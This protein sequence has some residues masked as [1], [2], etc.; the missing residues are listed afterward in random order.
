MKV[1]IVRRENRLYEKWQC[2]TDTEEMGARPENK[3]VVL[4][5]INTIVGGFWGFKENSTKNG[6]IHGE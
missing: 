1:F 3:W 6:T 4:K 5:G 2:S